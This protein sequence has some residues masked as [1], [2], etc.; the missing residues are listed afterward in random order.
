MVPLK[1]KFNLGLNAA[2]VEDLHKR[3]RIIHNSE[4]IHS[5]AI[6]QI[7]KDITETTKWRDNER[8]LRQT[9]KQ[10][11]QYVATDPILK[12]IRQGIVTNPKIRQ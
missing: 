4:N 2:E 10:L 9:S 8:K 12:A 6:P 11:I 3:K 1:R 7:T 5:K